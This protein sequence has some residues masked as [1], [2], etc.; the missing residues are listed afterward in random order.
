MYGVS[1][2]FATGIPAAKTGGG[3]FA[4]KAT[5]GACSCAGA[6]KATVAGAGVA[7]AKVG[8]AAGAAGATKTTL[9]G[10]CAGVA[11]TKVGS[12]AGGAAATKATLVGAGVTAAKL[13]AA[14]GATKATLAG[15]C[16][17]VAA[18]KVG[19]AAG[20]AAVCCFEGSQQVSMKNGTVKQ[21]SMIKV[22][23]K[24][25]TI[26]FLADG[27]AI[28]K[29]TTVVAVPHAS[30]ST[31]S[32]FQQLETSSAKQLMV[33]PDH[34]LLV[35][36]GA[37]AIVKLARAIERGDMLVTRDG[38]ECVVSTTSVVSQG[39]YTFVT[40]DEFVV[41]E[42]IVASPY[43]HYHCIPHW[44]FNLHR[45]LHKFGMGKATLWK[46]FRGLEWL[47]LFISHFWLSTVLPLQHFASWKAF[48]GFEWLAM[49]F[50]LIYV[51]GIICLIFF[52]QDTPDFPKKKYPEVMLMHRITTFLYYTKLNFYIVFLLRQNSCGRQ[53]HRPRE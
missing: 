33:T 26:S 21:I 16:A 24:V 38:A 48:R 9:A 30:N 11:A 44:Y 22:G 46:A 1:F 28:Q 35:K 39:L 10:A 43:G 7:A 51:G 6:T 5:L 37:K 18:V 52:S 20:A 50:I 27:T 40:M 42:G 49:L 47:A 15:A 29:A 19:A 34:L 45:T 2:A 14:A 12:A 31:V 36:V 13:G 25:A 3:V 17:G 53:R 8:A 4:T 41:V 32:T 23:D